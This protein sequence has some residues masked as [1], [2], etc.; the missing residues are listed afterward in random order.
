MAARAPFPDTPQMGADVPPAA[1]APVVF[2]RRK[3]PPTQNA[4]HRKTRLDMLGAELMLLL[5]GRQEADVPAFVDAAAGE[6]RLYVGR[7][8]QLSVTIDAVTSMYVLHAGDDGDG[9]L[10]ITGNEG[11]LLDHIVGCIASPDGARASR[12]PDSVVDELVGRSLQEVERSLVLRTL[13]RFRGD[14]QGAAAVLGISRETLR[15]HIR[16]YLATAPRVPSPMG[17][18]S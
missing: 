16:R 18:A 2:G 6:P 3:Q 9:C 15:Q 4:A 7:G 10:I 14:Y 8:A 5:A 1:T 17:D 12:V 13:V 11:R